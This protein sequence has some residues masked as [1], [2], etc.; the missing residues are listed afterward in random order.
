MRFVVLG[1][2]VYKKF[3]RV[4]SGFGRLSRPKDL[5]YLIIVFLLNV[6]MIN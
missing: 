2:S 1:S 3:L 6:G 5:L 4:K